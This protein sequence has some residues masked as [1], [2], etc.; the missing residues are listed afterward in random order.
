MGCTPLATGLHLGSSYAVLNFAPAPRRIPV[1]DIVAAVEG[2]L[3]RIGSA[4]AQLARTRITGCLAKARP[5]PTNLSPAEQKAIRS[6]KQAEDIIITPADKG[7]ATVVM[8]RTTYDG[9]IRTLLADADTYKALPRDPTPALERKM[10]A[11]LL[12]LTREGAIPTTLY[13]RLRSSAGKVP[14]LYGLPKIYKPETPLRPIVSFL[15]SPTYGLSK[16]LVS[17]LSPLVGKS[18]SHV[19]NSAEFASFIASQT[20]SSGMILVSFDVVSLFTR[21]PADLAISVAGERLKADSSLSERTALSADQV[22]KLLQFCLDATYLAYRGEF[23]KQTFGTAM[24]SPVLVTVANLVMESVEERALSTYQSPVP[25]WKRYVDDTVTAL[26]QDQVKAFHSHLNTIEASIQFTVEEETD[27]TLPFLDTK[28]THHIDGSLTTT[29]FRKSTHTDRYL[30]FHSHHPLAHKVSVARTLL[31]RAEK[32][33]T[34]VPDREKEKKHVA[35]PLHNNGYSGSLVARD[36]HPSTSPPCN[37][38]EDVPKATVTLPY[39]R[40]LS[41]CIRRILSP[42]GIRTCFRPHCTLRQSLVRVK[43]PTPAP[44]RTGAVYRIP[45]GNCPKVY[46]GQTSRTLKHRL[47]EHKRA[48][49]SGEAAQSAVAEHAMEEDHI[50]KWEDSEVVDHNHRYRQRCTLEAWHIRTERH[51]MNRDE[52]PLPGVYNPLIHLY[53]PS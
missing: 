32:I 50:I 37:P 14:L 25:F 46:I 39:I 45:C 6:L 19:K 24:G 15:N 49:R 1:R 21:V 36:W 41:E 23:F 44:Q 48:L 10:N 5:P 8:D 51:K 38:D 3:S 20:L 13:N 27:N 31:R 28:I 47:T 33:C 4:E 2:G 30:D 52:G 16:H 7:N 22:V 40:H 12:S 26:P 17:I 11:L 29:V 42:L 53:T 9:K 35:Q 18:T 43:D 34:D